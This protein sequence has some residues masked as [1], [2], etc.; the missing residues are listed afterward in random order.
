MGIGE[1]LNLGL[2]KGIEDNIKPIT[3]AMDELEGATT[4]K[5]TKDI[6]FN[7]AMGSQIGKGSYGANASSKESG[8]VQHIIVNSPEA[9]SPSETARQI[10]NASRNL[11]WSGK[12]AK[13]T[14]KNERGDTLIFGDK[15]PF[16]ITEIEGLGSPKNIIYSTKSAYQDGTTPT[17]TS[18]ESRNL[19]LIGFIVES[20][21]AIR[22][23][24]RTRLL[25]V[26]NPKF[27]GELFL[28]IYGVVKKVDCI[29]ELAPEFPS[30]MT[31]GY[32]KF[33]IQ[34]D[35]SDPFFKDISETGTDVSTEVGGFEF[36][37]EIPAEGLELSI[38]TISYITNIYNGGSVET[39]IRVVL[40]AI[41]TV[42]NPIITNLDTGEFIKVKRT[43][44][45]GDVL[46]INTEFGNKRVEIIRDDGSRENVFNYIDYKSKFFSIDS[47]DTRLKYGADL[48]DSNLD[49]YILHS[50]IFR[51]IREVRKWKMF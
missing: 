44:S 17:H 34:L 15:A 21:K 2:A 7:A 31:D 39:P 51:S 13:L 5:L 33:S 29:P 3:K 49:V 32:Q 8:I 40:R 27:K 37:L 36:P 25:E 14:Y 28:E 6:A 1:Y 23:T 20:D 43:L 11:Q 4:R 50:K 30:T 9:L 10:K 48:G 41:G 22:H 42:E 12:M 38:R 19:V 16:L 26:F 18:L 35:C 24:L 46:E 45:K 47:G